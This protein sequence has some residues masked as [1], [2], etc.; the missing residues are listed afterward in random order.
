MTPRNIRA[1][2][3]VFLLALLA[4]ATAGCGEDDSD[5]PNAAPLR[6]LV[7]NDDGVA[8]DGID[9]IVQALVADPRNDVIVSAP[10]GNRSGTGD[11]T[12]PSERCGD[13]TVTATTTKSGYAATAI[14]G[15]PAD[16]VNY[17]LAS[18][19]PAGTR[20]HV[21]ISGINAGQNVSRPIAT[22]VSGT[23]GAALTAGRL[24]VAALAS[25]QGIPATGT[26]YDFPAGVEA[27]V[28]WLEDHRSS[29][30]AGGVPITAIANLNIPT[31]SPGS[32]IRGTII[33]I[34]LAPTGF[35]ILDPQNCA[36]TLENPQTDVEAFLNGYIAVS[37]V[38]LEED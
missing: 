22:R 23:V 2:L 20:P 19:Y 37:D 8:A 24:G 13:L 15:C 38:P 10:D 36:S 5:S 26:E 27:T 12:G 4:L 17:A 6:V 25:S 7:T 18:L 31:C 28:T 33:D 30:Q 14:N 32:A 9:A 16:A 29:L 34:P 11:A 1:I 21:V 35:G 3:S